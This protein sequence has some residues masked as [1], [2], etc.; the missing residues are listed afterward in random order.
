MHNVDKLGHVNGRF[1]GIT[2]VNNTVAVTLKSAIEEV[3]NKHNLSIC[4][5]REKGY[6]GAS[7]LRGKLNGLK[8]LI[9]KDNPSTYY[10]HCF[11]PQLQLTLVAIAKNHIQIA[12]FFN[13][14][15]KVFNI[16]GASC[17][18]R[19]ILREKCSAEVIEALKNNEI[20]TGR[21]L[22]QEMSLKDLE[23]HVGVLIMVHLLILL[24]Y[25]LL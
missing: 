22:N 8:T 15:A 24:T 17:K 7:N 3:F 18:H 20:S 16:V 12:T 14:V 2:H 11:A 25:F 6:D 1:L 4:R 23:I 21:G 9:L 19:D 5:L 13:L 10:V